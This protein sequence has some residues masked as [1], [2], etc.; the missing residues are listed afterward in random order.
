M[1]GGQPGCESSLC[2][3]TG[4]RCYINIRQQSSS[5]GDLP[6]KDG[7][8][9]GTL[10]KFSCHKLLNVRATTVR[11]PLEIHPRNAV[12]MI[13]ILRESQRVLNPKRLLVPQE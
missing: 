10:P 13:R 7:G 3:L 1:S 9:I 8:G 11:L 5:R 12:E 4:R 2:N 6:V